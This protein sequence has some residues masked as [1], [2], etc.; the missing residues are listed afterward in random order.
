M[1]HSLWETVNTNA[2]AQGVDVSN[3][4]FF[5][6]FI[7]LLDQIAQ[8]CKSNGG[9]VRSP[10]GRVRAMFQVMNMSDGREKL[11]RHDRNAT[12]IPPLIGVDKC[13]PTKY[14]KSTSSSMS[15]SESADKI[16][17]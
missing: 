11:A 8:N 6:E 5:V 4:L 7:E 15:F 12:V 1:L 9:D 17:I 13:E 10:E 16:K 2:T 14:R 3:G